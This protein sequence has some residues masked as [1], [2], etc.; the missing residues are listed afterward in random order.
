MPIYAKLGA[1]YTIHIVSNLIT[2]FQNIIILIQQE[3]EAQ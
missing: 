2:T 3:T 1:T